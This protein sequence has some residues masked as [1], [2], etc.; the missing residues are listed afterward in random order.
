MFL[1]SEVPLYSYA[2]VGGYRIGLA[3]RDFDIPVDRAEVHN[4][5]SAV[6]A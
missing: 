6:N 5:C 1:V 2:G 4:P 3:V